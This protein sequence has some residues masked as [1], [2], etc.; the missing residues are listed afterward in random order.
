MWTFLTC[1]SCPL[2]PVGFYIWN[3]EIKN[4]KLENMLQKFEKIFIWGK[5]PWKFMHRLSRNCKSLTDKNQMKHFF[6]WNKRFLIIFPWKLFKF[7]QHIF[8]ILVTT[9]TRVIGWSCLHNFFWITLYNKLPIK[10]TTIQ[11]GNSFL[12][13]LL[14][15]CISLS[16]N[17]ICI[18]F[19]MSNMSTVLLNFK[20]DDMIVILEIK[21]LF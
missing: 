15:Y 9:T 5:N 21:I 1:N 8:Y 4:N 7:S 18:L 11:V 17:N 14:C 19:I 6:K 20:C 13:V 10:N 16:E 2:V 12:A 3:S